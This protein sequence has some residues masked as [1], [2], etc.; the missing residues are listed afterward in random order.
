MNFLNQSKNPHQF[1]DLSSKDKQLAM[2]MWVLAL[3]TNFVGPLILWVMKK[4]ESEYLNQQGKNYFNYAISYAIYGVV[5]LILMVILIGY[6]TT[7]VL[8]VVCTVYTILGIITTNKGED[9][10]VPFTINIIK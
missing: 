5:S 2:L 9:Y 8:T 10:V 1:Q 3:F 4:D 6:I 7:F